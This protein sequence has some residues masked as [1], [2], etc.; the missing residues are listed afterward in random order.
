MKRSVLVF[1]TSFES[2]DRV[3]ETWLVQSLQIANNSYALYSL[4]RQENTSETACLWV[5]DFPATQEDLLAL[6]E[7]GMS[8]EQAGAFFKEA[9]A[10]FVKNLLKTEDACDCPYLLTA[11][12]VEV[13][14]SSDGLQHTVLIRTQE[15]HLLTQ[16]SNGNSFDVLTAIRLGGQLCDAVLYL[17]SN[18]MPHRL[19]TTDNIFVAADGNFLLGSFGSEFDN[20]FQSPEE[21]RGETAVYNGKVC[22]I[23][24]ILYTVLND[25]N[26]PLLPRGM[27]D[28]TEEEIAAAVQ[29]RH[30]GVP[31]PPPRHC[32]GALT[33]IILKAGAYKAK[34][35]YASVADLKTALEGLHFGSR[36]TEKEEE[37]ETVGAF[38]AVRKNTQVRKILYG[39][40]TAFIVIVVSTVIVRT[41]DNQRKP[42]PV[43]PEPSAQRVT[44]IY[45]DNSGQVM[46]T[47]PQAPTEV[48]S[49]AP[50]QPTVNDGGMQEYPES[51]FSR[52]TVYHNGEYYLSGALEQDGDVS[53]TDLALT[54]DNTVYMTSDIDGATV[55][56]LRTAD[57]T[58]F[59]LHPAGKAYIELNKTV[60]R[61]LGMSD[62]SFASVA[63]SVTNTTGFVPADSVEKTVYR[64]RELVACTYRFDNGKKEVFYL[65]ENG[66]ICFIE[67]YSDDNT[68]SNVLVVEVLTAEVPAE[69]RSIPSDYTEYSGISGLLNFA[70]GLAPA[71]ETTQ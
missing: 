17:E 65:D 41:Y 60:M 35:R 9:A 64:D 50:L 2:G 3:F 71:A 66:E 49:T 27:D 33:E 7:S 57:G 67:S 10:D 48:Q 51:F 53:K 11:D 16:H 6:C 26:V 15:V 20:R 5:V 25:F 61:I 59:L 22:S 24:I 56:F 29:S 30:A 21:H 34:A 4:T 63:G 45:I 69:M 46:Q 31:L 38:E 47:Q 8:Q 39:V 23:G 14:S 44:D 12:A 58:V 32:S 70:A 62:E 43:A 68:L 55:G 19:L 42:L 54:K 28:F 52:I 40:L 1:L 37:P 36:R 13:I 18:E